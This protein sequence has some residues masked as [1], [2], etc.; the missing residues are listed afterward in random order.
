[1]NIVSNDAA[2]LLVLLDGPE[3][4]GAVHR[5]LLLWTDEEIP[6]KHQ[7]IV[8]TLLRLYD[9][10]WLRIRLDLKTESS[11]LDKRPELK[12][13]GQASKVVIYEL[14]EAGRELANA[15]R[16]AIFKL[17]YRGE[18]LD[19]QRVEREISNGSR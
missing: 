18:S 3:Y 7:R 4:V 5:K 2:V 13:N 16:L 17:I 9:G 1:M 14:T 12:R 6:I 19:C 8:E 15:Y 11:W 10:G